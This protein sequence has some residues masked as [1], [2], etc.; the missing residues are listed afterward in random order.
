[1]RGKYIIFEGGEGGGKTTQIQALSDWLTVH[2]IDHITTKE[3][4]GTPGADALRSILLCKNHK[5]DPIS[6]LLAMYAARRDTLTKIVEPALA[7][8]KWVLSDRAWPSSYAYQG[9]YVPTKLIDFLQDDVVPEHAYGDCLI[10]L[11]VDPK[12]GLARA[13]KRN[14]LDKNDLTAFDDQELDFHERVLEQYDRLASEDGWFTV[15]ANQS[16]QSVSEQ[17]RSLITLTPNG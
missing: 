8:G 16:P 5:L 4:G 11:R 1:M 7:A 10:H 17:I 15:D 2:G 3:P 6:Q 13:H 9:P 14:E 12:I